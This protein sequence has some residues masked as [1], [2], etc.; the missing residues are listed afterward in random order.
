M[1]SRGCGSSM[2]GGVA[3]GASRCRGAAARAAAAARRRRA[4]KSRTVFAGVIDHHRCS[5]A[6]IEVVERQRHRASVWVISRI[7]RWVRLI[8]AAISS[9]LVTVAERQIS[10]TCSGQRMIDSSQVVPRSGSARKWIS[11]KMTHIDVVEIPRASAAAC[12]AGL[13]WSSP[14]PGR[15]G[16]RMTS[17]VSSPTSSP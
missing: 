13:R 7:G 4:G 2:L 3:L 5:S 12:C 17:P 10:W 8:Q 15:P 11:S 6:S 9:A 16:S 1:I 14:R